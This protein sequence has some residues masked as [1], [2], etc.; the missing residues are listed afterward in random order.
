MPSAT[1]RQRGFVL[2]AAAFLLVILSVLALYL[3]HVTQSSQAV[4][5]LE[6]QGERGYWAAQSGVEAAMYQL[7]HGA[8]CTASQDIVLPEGFTVT[9][10]CIATQTKEGGKTVTVYRLFGVA[11]NQPAA[12][13]A[14]PNPAPSRRDYV[15]RQVEVVYE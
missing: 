14:C 10:Q 4:S 15:E 13:G 5:A 9:A 3:I 7:T 2:P 6:L 11:C 8:V 12:D 1:T